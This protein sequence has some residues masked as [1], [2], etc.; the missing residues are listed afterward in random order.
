MQGATG[1]GHG[2]DGD[3]SK[4]PRGSTVGLDLILLCR[5]ALVG[6]LG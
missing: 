5:C 6:E 2:A 1:M 3:W 4:L